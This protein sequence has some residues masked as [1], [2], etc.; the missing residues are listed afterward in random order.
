MVPYYEHDNIKIYHGDSREILPDI[1]SVDLVVTDPPYVFGI[2]STA[3]EGK[4]GGWGDMMNAAAWYAI[5][6]K[7]LRRA[8]LHREG[9]VWMFNSWRSFPVLARAAHEVK[10]PIESLLVWDKG[11]LG[12]GGPRGLRPTYELV[13]L[14]AHA[15]FKI[16]NRSVPDVMRYEWSPGKRKTGH[17]AEKSKELISRLIKE[18]DYGTILD[19]FMGSGTTLRAAKEFGCGGIGIEIE[20]RWCEYAAKR[21]AQEVF[22]L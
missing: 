10:W 14:F 8:T 4:C 12:P 6:L 13:A 19:P 2:A 16:H 22:E 15:E 1:E 20:E 17:P 11:G 9:A 3:K 18:S 21:L 7:Q 5:T